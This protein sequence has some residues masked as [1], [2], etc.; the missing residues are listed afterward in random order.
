MVQMSSNPEVSDDK[1]SQFPSIN[2]SLRHRH[3]DLVDQDDCF[4]P[5]IKH[6][7]KP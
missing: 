1:D 2:M 6:V 4:L 3:K 5:S 7:A